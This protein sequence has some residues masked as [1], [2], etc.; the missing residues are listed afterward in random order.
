MCTM[1]QTVVNDPDYL[2]VWL[3][4]KLCQ[5][6]PDLPAPYDIRDRTVLTRA[7]ISAMWRY[8]Y[9]QQLSKHLSSGGVVPQPDY[10]IA[11][12]GGKQLWQNIGRVMD[13]WRECS[14]SVRTI[15]SCE[16]ETATAAELSEMSGLS[17]PTVR[18]LG[19]DGSG[20]YRVAPVVEYVTTHPDSLLSVQTERGIEVRIRVRRLMHSG[21]T[22]SPV[23]TNAR[24]WNDAHRP[25]GAPMLGAWKSSKWAA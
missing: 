11:D 9:P 24:D 2:P 5:R 4:T 1:D 20:T 23:V 18:R 6:I 17:L 7:D 15:M 3:T 8:R 13:C 25:E 16:C 21:I 19:A 14:I 22:K 10:V 12:I